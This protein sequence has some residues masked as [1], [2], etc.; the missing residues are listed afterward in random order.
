MTCASPS[1]RAGGASKL[2]TNGNNEF[3][4]AL[5]AGLHQRPGNLAFS[6]FGIRGV[7]GMACAG[8]C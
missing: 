4:L 5:Y 7:L 8:P 2:F 3:A 1:P 6:P